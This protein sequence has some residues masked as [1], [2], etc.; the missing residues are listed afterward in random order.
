M[1]TKLF[2]SVLVFFLLLL[3]FYAV[4]NF[5][6]RHNNSLS[7]VPSE[8]QSEQATVPD[9]EEH[10]PSAVEV[11]LSERTLG[12]VAG[13]DN[14]LYYY[15]LSEKALRR[16]RLDGK[17]RETLLSNLPG[18][19]IRV[20]WSPNREKV[21]LH[22][23]KPDGGSQW[24]YAFILNK[25]LTPLNPAIHTAAWDNTGTKI[26]YVFS[27]SSA[28]KSLDMADPDGTNWRTLIALDAKK[29]YFIA[30]IPQSTRIAY[31]N[32]PNAFEKTALMSTTLSGDNPD[33]LLADRNGAD[34]RTA[35]D[36]EHIL[37]S[38]AKP[39]SEGDTNLFVTNDRGGEIYALNVPTLITKTTWSLDG[40]LIYY[41]LPTELPPNTIFPNEYFEK[42]LHSKDTFWKMDI[43]TGKTARLVA[44]DQMGKVSYDAIDLFLSPKE[45]YLYF[46]DRESGKAFRIAL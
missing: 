16:S 30:P 9:F 34:Y 35:P 5:K 29:D 28:K 37:V 39:G 21:L 27:E 7:S 2:L 44:P 32:R 13:N 12:L 42:G 18:E 20:L 11:V 3:G 43:A 24:H 46:R 10:S 1:A 40:K 45:D 36:G 22:L 19:P 4:Y 14:T 17:D 25:T 41:A 6:Y 33:T 31:W 23:R 26:M 15:S 8:D 38:A